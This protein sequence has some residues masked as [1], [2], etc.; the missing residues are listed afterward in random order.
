MNRSRH[1]FCVASLLL[2][3]LQARAQNLI[4]SLSTAE[5][6]ASFQARFGPNSFQ[7]P[8]NERLAMLRRYRKTEIY[9]LSMIDGQR[10][11]LFS[12]EGKNFE[13]LPSLGL[14]QPLTKTKAYVRGVEREWRTQPTPGAFSTPESIYEISLDGSN[15]FHRLFEIKPNLSTAVVNPAGTEDFFKSEDNGKSLIYIYD[16]ATGNLLHTWD[17]NGLLKANCPGCL[18]E[19]QGWLAG[20]NRLFFNLDIVGDDGEDDTASAASHGGPGAYSVAED[21][22]DL[23]EIPP[24]TGQCKVP[25][26]VRLAS[27]APSLIGQLPDGTY[28]FLDYAMKQP[29]PKAPAQAQTF[30]VLAKSGAQDKKVIALRPSRLESFHLSPSGK[31]LAFTEALTTKDYRSERHLWIKNLQ[32]GEDKEL[33][34]VP[35]PNPPASPQP[36]ETVVVL[37]WIEK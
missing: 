12:D 24:E 3:S 13:I 9:S 6:Q 18:A 17:L 20:G 1:L 14:G 31:Y 32:S 19:S 22:S 33:F 28:V 15:K 25:G 36:N 37:G 11:L 16:V 8:V 30:L 4:Y 23:R 29:Q 34:A 5:T 21:G 2:V 27:V 26:Y 7:R 10:T 35:P